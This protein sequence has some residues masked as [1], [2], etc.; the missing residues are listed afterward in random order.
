[1]E[2]QMNRRLLD[3]AHQSDRIG[4]FTFSPFLSE[5]EY[6]DFCLL[7]RQLPPCGYTVWGGYP[8][9]ERVM[10]RFGDPERLGYEEPFPIV[11]LE[12]A[13]LQEKFA[14]ALTH[15]DFLGALMHLGISRGE[16]GDIPVSGKTGYLFCTAQMA[17]YIS[18]VLERVRHT[19]VRCC[20]TDRLPETFNAQT[21]TETVQA[22]SLRADLLI[23]KVFRIS[24]SICDGCF[25]SEK[26]FING[27][28][29]TQP[30]AVLKEGDRVSVRGF[31]KFRFCGVTGTT[32]KGNLIAEIARFSR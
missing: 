16:L 32:R 1:M 26:V 19:S 29:V 9:A 5:A 14:D 28:T 27:R 6:A 18:G 7:E 31:G 20:I 10:I 22:A 12:I 23:A 4:T 11:C 15:R 8:D 17:D 13:P 2:E 25:A 21:V 24:R 3:L 30:A